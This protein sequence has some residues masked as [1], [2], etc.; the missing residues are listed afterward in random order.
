MMSMSLSINTVLAGGI[1]LLLIAPATAKTKPSSTI[2]NSFDK[3][4]EH[5]LAQTQTRDEETDD[6]TQTVTIQQ[7]ALVFYIRDKSLDS[8]RPNLQNL[9]MGIANSGEVVTIITKQETMFKVRFEATDR[10]GWVWS[11]S[12]E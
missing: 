6:T 9:T 11:K 8:D 1:G 7:L 3:R 12:F 2:I 5:N 10:I 4:A